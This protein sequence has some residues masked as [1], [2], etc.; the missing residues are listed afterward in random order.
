MADPLLTLGRKPRGIV[1]VCSA[2]P[3]VIAASLEEAMAQGQYGLIE[4]TCNRSI[5]VAAIQA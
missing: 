3:L 4:C 5:T 2:H 1:S